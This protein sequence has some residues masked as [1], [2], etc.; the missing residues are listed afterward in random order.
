MCGVGA[1]AG[2][3]GKLLLE[4][5]EAFLA[6]LMIGST[7]VPFALAAGTVIVLGFR[8]SRRK[9][10]VWGSFLLLIPVAVFFGR[11]LFFPTGNPLQL[12]TTRRLI[13]RRL[14]QQIEEPWV[15]RE[16]KRRLDN[17]KLTRDDVSDA[18]EALTL[19]MKTTSPA[20]W[21]QPLPWQ[22]DFLSSVV[23]AKLVSD[24]VLLDLCDAFYGT[25]PTVRTSVPVAAG[26]SGFQVGVDF[27]NPWSQNSGLGTELLWDVKQVLLDGLPMKVQRPNRF[28]QR[29]D[30]FCEGQLS[31]G[32]HEL[33][34][35]VECAY[36]N[37]NLVL[38]G[39]PSQI[40]VSQW[41]K[42][43]K[44]WTSTVTS[45]VKVS[46]AEEK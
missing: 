38:G 35:E 2:I 39:D 12:L 42:A 34:I 3:M 7:V 25:Q 26:Q 11:A 10:V 20:G 4:R 31:Q 36:V 43:K 14:P 19:H 33:K 32:D 5:P 41:P 17:S 44:Q 45:L 24:E 15:W 18:L 23:G 9:L 46:E 8:S 16:L 6:V 27:G 1:A 28:A 40:P 30:G 22:N 21:N 37:K 13:E 29:W